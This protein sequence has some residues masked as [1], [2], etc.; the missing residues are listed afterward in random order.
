MKGITT[1]S[2]ANFVQSISNQ[3][4]KSVRLTLRR[5]QDAEHEF[6]EKMTWAEINERARLQAEQIFTEELKHNHGKPKTYFQAP[7]LQTSRRRKN[8]E[9]D[10]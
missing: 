1:G 2:R 3:T 10:L 5:L 4:I 6:E 8:V 9:E 7:A